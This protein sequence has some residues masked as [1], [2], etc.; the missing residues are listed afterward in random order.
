L[1]TLLELSGTSLPPALEGQSLAPILHGEPADDERAVFVE[2][3]R[4]AAQGEANGGFNPMRAIVTRHHKLAVNLLDSDELY[5]LTADPT[6]CRN[7]ID[8][9]SLG[10]LRD[11]LHDRLIDWQH[12][13]RDP[14]R[15]PAWERRPWRQ[16]PP[17]LQHDGGW[18]GD[19]LGRDDGYSAPFT[20][21]DPMAVRRW[22]GTA[23]AAR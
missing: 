15:G 19:R 7:L 1:P 20:Q 8:E 10:A 5:D 23:H 2:Y 11:D 6:E 9:P 18:S 13:V 16:R 17:R 22:K 12:A 14:F 3:H 21:A 4:F